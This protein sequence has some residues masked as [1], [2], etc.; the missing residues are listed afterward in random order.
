M[1]LDEP[2]HVERLVLCF[3]S[4]VVDSFSVFIS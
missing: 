3:V 2:V 4:V 1:D